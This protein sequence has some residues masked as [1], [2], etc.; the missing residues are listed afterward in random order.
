MHTLIMFSQYATC[1]TGGCCF[2]I[3]VSLFELFIQSAIAPAFQ[4]YTNQSGKA[5]YLQNTYQIIHFFKTLR[6]QQNNLHTKNTYV[7]TAQQL[8][9]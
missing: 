7:I 1:A 2:S 4:P 9:A 8:I 5:A 3:C 6:T